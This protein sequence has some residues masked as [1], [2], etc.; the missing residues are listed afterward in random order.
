MFNSDAIAYIPLFA[1]AIITGVLFVFLAII[2]SR[3]TAKVSYL[4]FLS[5]GAIIISCLYTAVH[6]GMMHFVMLLLLAALIILPYLIML[7][8]GKPKKEVRYEP[9][10]EQIKKPEVIVED[11]KPDEVNLI[12]K[13]RAF[14]I[15]ASDGFGKPDGMQALLDCIN[16]TC[17]EITNADGGAVLLVDDFEDSINVKSFAGSFPPPYQLPEGMPHKELR[18]STSFKFANFPLRDNIFG[19]IASSGKAE[20]INNPKEDSRIFENGPEDF[21]KLG[22]YIFIPV[23]LRGKGIVIGLIALS[24]NPDKNGFTQKEYDWAM[25]LA[26]FAESALKTSYSFLEYNDK[27]EMS[28]ESEIAGKLQDVLL[29]KKLPPLTGLSL[30]SYTQ[31]TEGVCSDVFDVIP[32]RSDRTSFI[33]MDAAGKGTNSF[34]VMSMIRAMVRL[35]V[36]TPQPAGTILN[37][38]NRE[39]CGEMNFEHFASA[40]L[41]NFN[42]LNK[43]VQFS[44][45]GTTPVLIYSASTGNIERKSISCEPLGVEKTTAYKDNQFTVSSGDIIITYTD[46]LV[47][48]LN[49]SGKQYSADRLS[50]I[51]KTN[52]KLSGKQIAD[53]VK[54]DF[55]K[56][57]GSEMLHDDQTLLV[58]KIQ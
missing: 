57:V 39:I 40:S 30:G 2:K 29:P 24:K 37:W 31:H 18:V 1:T 47:E 42:P 33:L 48:A 36:N 3:K 5:L 50:T 14:V 43:T 28:K 16:Q 58:V 23:R 21:L 4:S 51:I 26:G 27:H 10:V 55:K 46:G 41:I 20:I 52:C 32:A 15:M 9:V 49:A 45:A 35:L 8:F 13:G 54:E 17:I 34:L 6:P 56:F 19:E 44:T 25:T 11:I 53:L 7:A 12:E 22:S 38:I